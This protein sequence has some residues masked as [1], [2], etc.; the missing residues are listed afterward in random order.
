MTL[1]HV[2]AAF[3]DLKTQLGFRPVFHQNATRIVG[4]LFI[5]VLAYHLLITIEHQLRLSGDHRTWQTIKKEL[6]TYVRTTIAF[7]DDKG[8]LYHVR[9]ISTPE[10]NHSTI[11]NA[12]S[13]P[14]FNK[15]SF[16]FIGSRS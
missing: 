5:G 7:N 6:S 8:D 4:Y 15:R 9:M 11:F 14:L 2:E 13:V 16:L 10:S 3:R 12:L 1:N